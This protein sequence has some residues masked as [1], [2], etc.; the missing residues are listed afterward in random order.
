[1]EGS[2]KGF[3]VL[4][5]SI[6]LVLIAV[7]WERS[8]FLA[9]FFWDLLVLNIVPVLKGWGQWFAEHSPLG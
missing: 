2:H 5:G 9:R 8:L 4:I 6:L 7:N 1:M 3:W